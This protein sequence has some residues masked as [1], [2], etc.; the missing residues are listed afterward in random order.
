MEM[1][2]RKEER[3]RSRKR[4]WGKRRKGFRR[5]LPS[6]DFPFQCS[7]NGGARFLEILWEHFS[8]FYAFSLLCS[9]HLSIAS[10]LQYC[11][12]LKALHFLSLHMVQ[13]RRLPP[14]RLPHICMEGRAFVVLRK[15]RH[16]VPDARFR[17]LRDIFGFLR[18]RKGG[19]PHGGLP[20]SRGWT[21]SNL[22]IEVPQVP[23]FVRFLRSFAASLKTLSNVMCSKSTSRRAWAMANAGEF[24]TTL[25]DFSCLS[26]AR[27]EDALQC[28]MCEDYPPKNLGYKKCRV[29]T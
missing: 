14:R 20:I 16:G 3:K 10:T 9:D 29:E 23:I 2:R 1:R 22:G 25:T 12:T 7:R 18:V 19:T 27:V 5:L 6:G 24:L 13:C 21:A 15:R 26:C 28:E 17:E 11:I 8:L 4:E